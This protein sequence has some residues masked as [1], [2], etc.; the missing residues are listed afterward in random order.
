MKRVILATAATLLTAVQVNAA[1]ITLAEYGVN[2][3]GNL[4]SAGVDESL[5][6]T[7][8]GLGAIR[9]TVSGAGPHSV[10]AYVDHEIDEV[11]NTFFNELGGTSG[12]PAP[13]E[14]WEIDEPGWVFG[15]IYTNFVA[16]ALDNSSGLTGP[17]DVS[18]ALGWDFSLMA[19]ET[20]HVLFT[21][22]ETK[23]PGG[24]YLWQYDPDSDAY[25]YFTSALTIRGGQV[26]EPGILLL[27]GTG[28][29]GLAAARRKHAARNTH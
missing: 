11:S 3:D 13:G 9:V 20:G 28:L 2:V 21:L 22:T 17:D 26:P 23:P 19:G 8:T 5:F 4:A 10:L 14:S 18:M 7:S 1:T 29:L 16:G 6:D 12:S 25:V 27:L 15:D 24:F